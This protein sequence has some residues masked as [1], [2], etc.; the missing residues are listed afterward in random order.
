MLVVDRFA[1]Q[2]WEGQLARVERWEKRAAAA[3]DSGSPDAEDFLL[4]F[5]QSAYHLRDWLLNSGTASKAD[6]DAV[7]RATPAL[8]L[9]RD[10]ANGSKHLTL[11]ATERTARVGLM[12]EY[13]PGLSSGWR[14]RMLA[15]ERRK[16]GTVEYH[17]IFEVMVECVDAWRAFCAELPPSGL[18]TAS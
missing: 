18:T 17:E 10:V 7:V 11:R 13:A 1:L 16:D 14:W 15:I 2:G 8:S 9:C 12:R 4:A 6:L 5:F 3:V